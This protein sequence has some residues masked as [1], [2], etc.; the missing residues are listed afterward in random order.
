MYH[1][2]WKVCHEKN[3]T[4]IK[5]GGRPL[6]SQEHKLVWQKSFGGQR[7]GCSANFIG[8]VISEG[9]L[10]G[11]M[12]YVQIFWDL[13]HESVRDEAWDGLENWFRHFTRLLSRRVSWAWRWNSQITCQSKF[14]PSPSVVSFGQWPKDRDFEGV[15]MNFLQGVWAQSSGKGWDIWKDLGAEFIAGC[16]PQGRVPEHAWGIT[17]WPG[18][19]SGSPQDLLYPQSWNVVTVIG[20]VPLLQVSSFR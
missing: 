16:Q 2:S 1:C 17:V 20:L 14:H 11:V 10:Q 8:A 9:D 13:V 5:L 19:A 4:M 15:R 3:V 18:N 6:G 12:S 7:E